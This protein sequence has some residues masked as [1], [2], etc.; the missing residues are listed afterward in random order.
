MIVSSYGY[1]LLWNNAS[2][3]EFNPA[4]AQVTLTNKSG[5]FTTTD[6]G[7]YAVFVKGGDR[8]NLIGVQINGQ[9]IVA[10]TNMWVT[11]NLSG[12][13]NLPANTTCS[14]TLLGG[15]RDA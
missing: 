1:G 2:L 6:A 15:G 10:I 4:D 14:V 5:T 7:D 13:V 12:R 11:Y 3:T 8:R 9:T